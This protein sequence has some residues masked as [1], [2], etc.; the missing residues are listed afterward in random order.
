MF[1]LNCTPDRG[2]VFLLMGYFILYGYHAIVVTLIEKVGHYM[3]IGYENYFV[4]IK[5][6]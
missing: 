5:L 3:S 6:G 2:K 4:W 1:G